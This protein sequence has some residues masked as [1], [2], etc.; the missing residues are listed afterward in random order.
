MQHPRRVVTYL[1]R[2]EWH[3][4]GQLS[5]AE[6]RDALTLPAHSAGRPMD[7]DAAEYLAAVAGGY[8]DALQVFGHHTWRAS[9][10]AQRITVEHARDGD[11]AGQRDLAAGL[12]TARWHDCSVRER[13]YLGALARLSVDGETTRGADIARSL[14]QPGSAVS[15]L[16][17]RLLEKGPCTARVG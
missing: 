4:V 1:E 6:T 12:Y 11:A 14:G 15:Y 17:A 9:H 16:K 10:A 3:S 5:R 13:Q 2:S 8:P 7:D